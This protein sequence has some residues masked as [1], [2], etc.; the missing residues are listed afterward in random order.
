MSCFFDLYRF[1]LKTQ[2]P[3]M[4][5]LL[6]SG[7]LAIF[8]L[9][10]YSADWYICDCQTGANPACQPGSDTNTGSI[11]QPWQSIQQA[12]NQF[13]TMMAGDS[14]NFCRGG[15]LQLDGAL[16]WVNNQCS[17]QQPC[18]IDAYTPLW[19]STETQRPILEQ[20][21]ADTFF[22]LANGGVPVLQ[23]GYIIR[24]LHLRGQNNGFGVFLFNNVDDVTLDNLEIEN[25]GVGV[26]LA[27]SNACSNSPCDQISERLSLTNSDIHDN[28]VQGFL[29]GADGLI[30][31]SNSFY[32]NGTGQAS[33]LP[34]LH[35]VYI[36][37]STSHAATNI[38]VTNNVLTGSALDANQN[39]SGASFVAHGV[40]DN[41]LVEGN[42]IYES[43]GHA[44]PGCW[45]LAIDNAYGTAEIFSRITIRGNIIENVGNTMLNL[46]ACQNCTIE[47]NVFNQ[48]HNMFTI[49]MNIATR[50]D[51]GGDATL[52]QIT[53]R[54]NSVYF[55]AQTGG[56]GLHFADEGQ[57]HEVISNA[58]EFESGSGSAC[59][60]YSAPSSRF[61]DRDFNLCH[62]N[63]AEWALSFNNLNNWQT[64]SGADTNSLDLDPLFD[65]ALQPGAGSAVINAGHPS[66]SSAYDFLNRAR[67]NGPD[68]GAYEFISGELIFAN[69]FD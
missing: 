14:I 66:L 12:N 10:A 18:L 56:T 50:T 39:C 19:D 2:V 58:I 65:Q 9:P 17:A 61:S 20:L 43:F 28:T 55:G 30:V 47:N 51:V 41:V 59:F 13:N 67:T 25:F 48:T 37:N 44:N 23:T 60:N 34:F 52:D 6:L 46:G 21:Q 57:L 42:H 11:D 40:L 1:N 16:R 31:D 4:K 32:R 69:S 63:G 36:A 38:R 27:G 7:F 3:I 15:A 62:S 8:S 68:I 54:N 35:N 45:G 29:G 22:D 5:A 24:N 26:F 64:V 53:V 33:R 49:A